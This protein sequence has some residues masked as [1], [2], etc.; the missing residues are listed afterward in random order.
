MVD[1]FS[2]NIMVDLSGQKLESISWN[3]DMANWEVFNVMYCNNESVS[4]STTSNGINIQNKE[5]KMIF[6]QV[7]MCNNR[8]KIE[9]INPK[10]D[11]QTP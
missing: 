1:V 11:L 6:A 9:T 8:A 10:V 5:T 4:V 3:K 2:L 7:P